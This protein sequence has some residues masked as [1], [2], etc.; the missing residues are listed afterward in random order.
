MAKNKHMGSSFDGFLAKEGLLDPATE[1]AEKRVFAWQ[2]C[3]AMDGRK[4]V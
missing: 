1:A 2:L 4:R 3:K